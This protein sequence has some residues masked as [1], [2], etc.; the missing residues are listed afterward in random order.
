MS[1][2]INGVRY[3]IAKEQA[4][5]GEQRI[6]GNGIFRLVVA[7]SFVFKV[8][9][10]ESLSLARVSRW[11]F[12]LP[13]LIY[14]ILLSCSW[15]VMDLSH[16]VCPGISWSVLHF[17]PLLWISCL[18]GCPQNYQGLC[19]TFPL[20]VRPFECDDLGQMNFWPSGVTLSVG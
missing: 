5:Q 7:I 19:R 9:H 13:R 20:D 6:Y 8:P 1:D 14:I 3:P 18:R 15:K 10:A 12:K 16:S 11:P 2:I 4:R 17:S